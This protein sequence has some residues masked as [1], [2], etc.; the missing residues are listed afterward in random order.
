MK[1]LLKLSILPYAIALLLFLI[2]F[3]WLNPGEMDLGG[4][5]GRVYFYDPQNLLSFTHIYFNFPLGT[6]TSEGS[7]YYLPFVF[8]LSLI[9]TFINSPYLLIGIHNGLKISL[10]FISV[11]WIINE[12]LYKEKN[13]KIKIFGG[14]AGGLFYLFNP[15]M[16][17]NYVHALPTHDQVFLNPLIF[18]LVLKFL[19]K[20]DFRYAICVLILTLIFGH[21]FSFIGAP[22]FF[23]FFPLGFIFIFIYV[24]YLRKKSIPWIKALFACLLFLG[25]HAYQLLPE[26]SNFFASNSHINLRLFNAKDIEQEA[27]VFLALLPIPKVSLRFFAQSSYAIFPQGLLI[28]PLIIVGGFLV[29][30]TDKRIFLLSGLFFLVTLFFAT[31]NITNIGTLFYSKLFYIPGFSMFRNFYGQWQFAFYFFYAIFFGQAIYFIFLRF[32]KK[33]ALILFVL[34][35]IFLPLNAW[36]FIN[37]SLVNQNNNQ[38]NIKIA[39]EMDPKFTETLDFI[40]SM[41][42]SGKFIDFPFSDTTHQVI[43][44]KNGGAYV[45]TSMVG[46][47][48]GKND[49]PG[50][51]TMSPYSDIF[52]ELSKEKK[53]EH[54]VSLFRMLNIRYILHNTD[55][56]I[57][58]NNFPTYPFSPDYVRKYMP[59]TQKEYSEYIQK[60]SEKKLYETGTYKIY[61]ITND[62]YVPLIYVAKETDIYSF[63]SELSVY[64]EA[65]SFFPGQETKEKRASYITSQECSFINLQDNCKPGEK[66]QFKSIPNISYARISPTLYKVVVTN[67]KEP[68]ILVLSQAFHTGWKIF[69]SNSKED[70][71]PVETFFNGEI[72]EGKFEYK[73]INN[74]FLKNIGK[75]ELN[76][77][78]HFTINGYA[79]AWYITPSLVQNKTEYALL[80]EQTYQRF[81]YLGLLITVISITVLLFVTAWGFLKRH[82]L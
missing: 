1:K 32:P 31:A 37:G 12:F 14:I 13:K 66:I 16:I 77:N 51:M 10:G 47:L 20:S 29:K 73:F 67:I 79:N 3:F 2:P 39:M 78:S 5:G 27:Q 55:E 57:Y 81:F 50:Y 26:I 6:G 45:G 71:T 17:E 21:N 25:L 22:P 46:R 42:G 19:L 36:N 11:Y 33:L 72:S 82:M 40:R 41:K 62:E 24:L 44:G 28:I 64:N 56:R 15:A 75:K 4:D 65:A 53:Y 54:L 52:W 74:E 7:F 43:Y 58:G 9:K 76:E 35:C 49:F 38:S 68:F 61:K 70:I 59:N 18:F 30:K 80:I 69:S 60:I 34:F 48:T 8:T 23:A 63:N